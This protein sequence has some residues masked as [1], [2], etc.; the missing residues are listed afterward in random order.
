MGFQITSHH[1]D[2]AKNPGNKST[3]QSTAQKKP[4]SLL[5]NSEE[6]KKVLNKT[7]DKKHFHVPTVCGLPVKAQEYPPA[8]CKAVIKGLRNQLVKDGGFHEHFTAVLA[9]EIEEDEE[10][11]EPGL[12]DALDKE[13]EAEEKKRM[14]GEEEPRYSVTEDEKKSV[15]KL[16][17]GLGHP[18]RGE[19]V[20]FMRAARVKGEIIRW[21]YQEF[22]C[23]SCEAKPRP[24]ANRPAAI[25]RT[26]QPCRVLG[27]DLIFLPEVGDGR[28]FPALSMVDWG[29]NY[30]MVQRVADKQPKTIWNTLWSTWGRTFGL[31]EVLITDDDGGRIEGR[32]TPTSKNGFWQTTRRKKV[33]MRRKSGP[34]ERKR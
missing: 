25:P 21:A 13:M 5:M 12:E 29:S 7:C 16:H 15:M 20:R 24:K 31:P 27:V 19:F 34:Q 28:L 23:P 18:Q 2:R 32:S 30:Q 4:T 17:K 10:E 1:V 9:K 3:Y 22:Q 6:M 8:F 26:Y 33:R 14:R 11:E